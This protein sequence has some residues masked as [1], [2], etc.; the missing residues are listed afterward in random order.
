MWLRCSPGEPHYKHWAMY[1]LDT[2]RTAVHKPTHNMLPQTNARGLPI[3]EKTINCLN[4]LGQI[5]CEPVV[6]QS[7]L[8]LWGPPINL[9]RYGCFYCSLNT[10]YFA[11][12]L[13]AALLSDHKSFLTTHFSYF[14]FIFLKY[15]NLLIYVFLYTI[16]QDGWIYNRGTGGWTWF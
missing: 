5:F 14:Y 7:G 9:L 13:L 15:F 12:K 4:S 8:A 1:E 16:S 10:A 6:T 3:Y 11:W 2:L